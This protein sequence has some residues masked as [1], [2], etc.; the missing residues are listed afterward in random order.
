MIEKVTIHPDYI[1]AEYYN[2]IAVI[3]VR[4][5]FKFSEGKVQP[6]CLPFT[7]EFRR[8]KL[9]DRDVTVAGWGDQEFGKR[10]LEYLLSCDHTYYLMIGDI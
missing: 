6:I 3:R 1:P 4:E 5:P 7:P 9:K 8:K 2:D 10:T